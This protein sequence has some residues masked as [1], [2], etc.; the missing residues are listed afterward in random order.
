MKKFI[1]LI[2]AL[3]GILAWQ[4]CQYEWLDPVDYVPP[5]P[6]DTTSF[7][8]DIIPIFTEGC[9][10][11]HTTGGIPPDLTPANAYAD[12]FAK[13]MI[14]VVNP[15]KSI[16]YIEVATGGSMAKYAPPGDPDDIILTWIK[17]GALNN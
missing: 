12:L 2:I 16:L 5:P 14:D 8:Q 1:L 15:E 10:S 17:E 3:M 4:S 13:N 7:S 6:G 9:V 11:C